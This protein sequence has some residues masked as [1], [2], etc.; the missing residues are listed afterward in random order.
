MS[1][2]FDPGAAI[3]GLVF[4]AL[5]IVFTL[6]ALDV[7][8]LELGVVVSALVIGLGLAVLASAASRNRERQ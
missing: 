5:G 8:E 4:V 2:R 3:V 7:W 1:G 6:E